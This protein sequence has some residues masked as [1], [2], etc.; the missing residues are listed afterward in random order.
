LFGV[1]YYA[2]KTNY[3][4][5][6]QWFQLELC[7]K[8]KRM[9]FFF[10]A[11][12]T[13]SFKFMAL[14]LPLFSANLGTFIKKQHTTTI[15]LFSFG[16]LI[17]LLINI[18]HFNPTKDQMNAIQFGLDY[19][20][21]K[22]VQND[23]SLGHYVKFLGGEPSLRY[24][25]PFSSNLLNPDLNYLYWFECDYRPIITQLDLNKEFKRINNFGDYKIYTCARLAK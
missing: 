6:K 7:P 15:E 12:A 4:D 17:L 1:T 24:G 25:P 23:W 13:L 2:K 19:S 9:L 3:F 8:M 11:L 5:L 21:D 14:A 22:N 10:A 18:N 20:G 16:A